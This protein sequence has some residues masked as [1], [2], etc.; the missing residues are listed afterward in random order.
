[1]STEYGVFADEG[2]LERQFASYNAADLA[3]ADY[4][5]HGSPDAFASE[6]CPDHEDEE[7]P[8]DGCEECAA[9]PPCS[10]CG[11]PE[12]ECEGWCDDCGEYR[13][14]PDCTCDDWES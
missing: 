2:C 4:R 6:L 3:A 7:Q 5:A 1:M 12:S 13:C 11:E 14:D 9:N 10:N 8:R